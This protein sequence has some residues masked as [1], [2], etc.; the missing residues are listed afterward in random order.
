M[1]GEGDIYIGYSQTPQLPSNG[2]A[3][4]TANDATATNPLGIRCRWKGN[5]YRYVLFS[6][7]T[8]DVASAAKG[9]AYWSAL[10]PQTP[11][12]TV[13]SD[14]SDSLFGINGAAGIFG[15]VV[16]DGYY[17]WIQ[18][19]GLRQVTATGAFVT[20]DK[21]IGSSTDL[22]FGR[23]ALGSNNTDVVFGVVQ[24][25]STSGGPTVLLQAMDW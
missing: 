13:T 6:N 23:I 8:G 3:P 25:G 15:G 11:T 2:G 9:A 21:I 1:A 22:T 16:T 20:G 17:T 5:T 7:G 24:S 18:C 19:A 14:E 4:D 10:N 12:Y